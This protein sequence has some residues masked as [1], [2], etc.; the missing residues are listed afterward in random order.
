VEIDLPAGYAL[1]SADAPAPFSGGAIS[2]YKPSAA[3]TKDGKTLIYKRNFFFGAG[4]NILFPVST[5]PQL[6]AYFE[7]VHKEDGHTITLKQAATS[8]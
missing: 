5:Y 8:N 2:E 4:G 3:V 6:K 1:D 7:Q